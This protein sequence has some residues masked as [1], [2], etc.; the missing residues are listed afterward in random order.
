MGLDMSIVAKVYNFHNKDK[1]ENELDFEINYIELEL[2]YWRKCSAIHNWFITNS[3][4]E[5]NCRPIYIDI[6][7]LVKLK[8]ICEEEI[9]NKNNK[10]YKSELEPIPGFFFGITEKDEWYYKNM[11]YSVKQLDKI[12]R[13]YNDNSDISLYYKASW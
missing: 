12:I 9:K 4:E 13:W 3:G 11:E 8:S 10:D 2:A 5:D 7:T 1:L 6:E